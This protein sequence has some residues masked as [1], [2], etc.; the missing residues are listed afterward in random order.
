MYYDMLQFPNKNVSPKP[1]LSMGKT[2][3]AGVISGTKFI[4]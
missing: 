1:N 4:Y 3:V 2:K